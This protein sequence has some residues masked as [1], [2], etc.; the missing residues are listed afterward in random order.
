MKKIIAALSLLAVGQVNALQLVNGDGSQ[1]ADVCIAAAQSKSALNAKAEEFGFSKFDLEQF[2][3]NGYSVKEFAKKFA[4][5]PASKVEIFSFTSDDN[6][7]ETKLCV[8]A[9]TSKEAFAEVK[10]KH[11]ANK[12]VNSIACNGMPLKAFA[13]KYGSKI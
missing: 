1:Y 2:T 4:A 5:K 6:V 13:K 11:F 9:V 3:C 10:A 8:A 12:S 7:P